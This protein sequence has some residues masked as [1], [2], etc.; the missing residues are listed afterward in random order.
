M[1]VIRPGSAPGSPPVAFPSCP[2]CTAPHILTWP[3]R[4]RPGTSRSRCESCA[5]DLS[6]CGALD[7]SGNTHPGAASGW[8]SSPVQGIKAEIENLKQDIKLYIIRK[9]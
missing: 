2:W 3:R 9:F 1:S 5:P 4:M 7:I 8:P 6:A